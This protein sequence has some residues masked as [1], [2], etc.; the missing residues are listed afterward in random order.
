[1]VVSQNTYDLASRTLPRLL[2]RAAEIARSVVGDESE[3]IKQLET[4]ID[5]FK[6]NTD[7][8]RELV[9]VYRPYIQKLIYTFHSANVRALYA[10]LAPEDAKHH[11]Y[12]PDRIDWRDYWMNI[13]MPGLR[14]H[15][16][17]QLDLHTRRQRSL[18]RFRSL[19]DLLDRAAERYGSR[20]R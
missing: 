4:R 13:H 1:M 5:T 19:V 7:L 2:K 10:S 11:P 9:E 12:R 17:G 8:A 18:P 16:F 14:R 20:P 15:I 6:D 3:R